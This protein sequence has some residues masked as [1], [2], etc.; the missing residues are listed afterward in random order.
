[1]KRSILITGCSTGIGLRAAEMLRERNYRVFATTRKPQDV[2]ALQ[3]RGFES[4]ILDVNDSNSIKTA[5]DEILQHTNGTLDALFNN[6]GYGLSGAVEDL[7]RDGLRSQ[8]ETN[9][10]G[11]FELTNRIIPIMRKQG[12][13]RIVNISSILG[14]VSLPY[15]G[16][17]NASKYA[18]EALTDALRLELQLQNTNISVSLIEPGPITSQFRNHTF[19]TAEKNLNIENSAHR[20]YYQRMITSFKEGKKIPFILPPDAVVKKLIHALENPRPKVRYYVTVPTYLFATLKRLL[21]YRAM[22]AFLRQV[23]KNM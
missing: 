21:P 13:G 2:V 16:A 8:F 4:F 17:Y 18:L 9:V 22:D 7:T 6:A 11:L 20:E 1:M 10:F 5:V 23:S 3:N 14:L 12:H 19:H 15:C